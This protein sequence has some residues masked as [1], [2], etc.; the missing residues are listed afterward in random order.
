[1]PSKGKTPQ[2]PGEADK[3]RKRRAAKSR[4]K[5]SPSA[6]EKEKPRHRNRALRIG[7][8]TVIKL[9]LAGLIVGL[10]VFLVL[11][12]RPFEAIGR[13]FYRSETTVSSSSVLSEVRDVFELSTA[14]LIYRT[15]FP[16]DY[17]DPE[18]DMQRIYQRI[19]GGQGVIRDIL[20]EAE[21][22]YYQA[23]NLA[24]DVGLSPDRSRNQFV[25]VTT[26][27]RA[28]FDLS[29]LSDAG[30]L[31][32]ISSEETENGREIRVVRVRMPPAAISD[33]EI[34]DSDSSSYDYP[35]AN[36]SPDEWRRVAEFVQGRAGQRAIELG[37]LDEARDRGE[38]FVR[39]MLTRAG[40]DRIDVTSV[41]TKDR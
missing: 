18:L 20:T 6:P 12:F 19:S 2:Q 14:E 40:F 35:D 28:G 21:Y 17:L 27:S 37:L 7:F 25:V 24:E 39:R 1:M 8:G 9:T 15:V 29:R 38:A 33:I 41:V 5:A 3:S 31:L 23:W 16:Y 13:F 4:E 10:A 22:E 32:T 34:E 11:R 30:Q 36:L 26:I